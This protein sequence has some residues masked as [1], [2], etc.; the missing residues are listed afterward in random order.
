M[1]LSHISHFSSHAHLLT[2][3]FI[4]SSHHWQESMLNLS[5]IYNS[6]KISY[7][8]HLWRMLLSITDHYVVGLNIKRLQKWMLNSPYPSIYHNFSASLLLVSY[9]CI[10]S[11]NLMYKNSTITSNH[12]FLLLKILH[13]LCTC[14]SRGKVMYVLCFY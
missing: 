4:L 9:L 5:L 11:M 8:S 13:Y 12:L 7:Y 2:V 3:N 10:L 6:L 1:L 14:R